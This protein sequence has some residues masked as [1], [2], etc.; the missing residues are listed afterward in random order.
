M[1]CDQSRDCGPWTFPPPFQSG[2]R[3]EAMRARP[4]PFCFQSLRP[5]P[6]TSPRVFVP[7]VP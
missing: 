5:E 6:L 7:T 4:V 1:G 2:E 3:I